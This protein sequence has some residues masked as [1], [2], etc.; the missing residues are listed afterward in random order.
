MSKKEF[1]Q[2]K[3]KISTTALLDNSF[4]VHYNLWKLA[5]KILEAGEITDELFER[6]GKVLAKKIW[7]WESIKVTLDKD[8]VL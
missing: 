1:I 3:L 5:D 6:I 7:F 2:Q 4:E 8:L